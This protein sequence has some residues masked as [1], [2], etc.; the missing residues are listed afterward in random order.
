M[1]F[2]KDKA[3]A[4]VAQDTA[5]SQNRFS[6]QMAII[7]PCST[8]KNQLTEYDPN[9]LRKLPCPRR[10]LKQRYD[11]NQAAKAGPTDPGYIPPYLVASGTD[12]PNKLANPV[13]DSP[14]ALVW[15]ALVDDNQGIQDAKGNVICKS[16]LDNGFDTTYIRCQPVPYIPRTTISKWSAEGYWKEGR[17][18]WASDH[19]HAAL[20]DSVDQASTQNPIAIAGSVEPGDFAFFFNKVDPPQQTFP[21]GF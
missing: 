1:P 20:P 13:I 3:L 15:I 6:E 7:S 9:D 19:R 16:I 10:V 11:A 21:S 12:D 4:Q 2:I 8:C 18:V 5:G 17:Q 14:Q